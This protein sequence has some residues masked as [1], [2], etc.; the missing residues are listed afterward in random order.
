M[1]KKR[2]KKSEGF[3]EAPPP[4]SDLNQNLEMKTDIFYGCFHIK[5]FCKGILSYFIIQKFPDLFLFIF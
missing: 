5:S 4:P 3:S 1:I 2:I